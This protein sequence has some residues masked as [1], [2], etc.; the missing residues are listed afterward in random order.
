M[1]ER[2]ADERRGEER[3]V[4]VNVN[5]NDVWC[6][7]WTCNCMHTCGLWLTG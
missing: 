3:R 6:S 7:F 5:V 4:N 1:S 2:P